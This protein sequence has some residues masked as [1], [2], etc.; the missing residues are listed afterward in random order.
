MIQP[1]EP[2]ESLVKTAIKAITSY[3]HANGLKVG[4]SLPGEGYFAASLGVSRAVM[5]E[6]FGA[7]TALRMIDV[8]NGRKPR[9]GAIDESVIATSLGH[10]VATAQ[11]SVLQVWDVRRS[12]ELR[13]VELA[14]TGRTDAEAEHVRDLVEAMAR[15]GEDLPSLIR[16]D[17]EFHQTIAQASRNTLFSQLVAAFAPLMEVAVPRAWQIQTTRLQRAQ[18]LRRHRDVARAIRKR[19]P[20]AAIAAMDAHFDSSIG[21]MR[22]GEPS[23]PAF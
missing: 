22:R 18:L 14:A 13:T 23:P 11:V 16:H 2:A 7:L 12:I 9:V 15:D 21:A 10:A 17:I 4:D 3:S 20:N 19:D 5:R 1:R 8:G 6:A